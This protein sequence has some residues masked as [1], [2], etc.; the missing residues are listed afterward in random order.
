MNV[1]MQFYSISS[2]DSRPVFL[3]PTYIGYLFSFLT[4]PSADYISK[5]PHTITS[6]DWYAYGYN[7]LCNQHSCYEA[8]YERCYNPR[9]WMH[10]KRFLIHS[11]SPF[12]LLLWHLYK[13]FYSWQ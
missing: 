4:K 6:T 13:Y 11:S 2:Y 3:L 10:N 12:R 5:K 7:T 8:D 9:Y 1:S